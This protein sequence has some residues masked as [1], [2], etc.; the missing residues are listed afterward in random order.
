MLRD[1]E[2][3]RPAFHFIVYPDGETNQPHPR[4]AT[5][6]RPLID[7]LFRL[8][9]GHI[10]IEQGMLHYEDRAA[11]FDYQDRYIPLSFKADDLSVLLRY[12]PAG[13]SAVVVGESYR[14]E[15]GASDLALER[16]GPKSVIPAVHGYVQA[17]L[18]L[19]RNAVYLGSLRLTAR[20]HEGKDHALE[21]S[22]A[23]KDFAQPR[24]QAKMAGELDMRLLDPLTGYTDAPEGM[25]RLELTAAGSAGE[26]RIDGA[27]HVEDGSYIGTGMVASGVGLDAHVHADPE[28]LVI[29]SI[30]A[31]FRQGG[32]MAGVVDLHPWLPAL[33]GAAKLEPASQ[34]GLGKN[35]ADKTGARNRNFAPP[36][37]PPL[38]IQVNG[39]VTA[40]FKDV[41]LDTLLEMVSEAPYQHLGLDALL[42]GTAEA[43]WTN[44]D[45]RTVAVSSALSLS[46]PG[47]ARRGEVPANGIIDA[48]YT[49]RDGAVELRRLEL[50]TP[51]SALEAHGR[52]GAYPITSPTALAVEFHS[53]NLNEFDSVLRDLGLKRNGTSGT[54]ALP[55]KLSGQVDFVHGS[56]AGSLASPHLAG[57]LSATGLAI[58]AAQGKTSQQRM[59]HFDSVSAEGSYAA[60]RINISQAVLRRGKSQISL[61]MAL[62]AA[63]G[64]EMGTAAGMHR[65]GAPAFD[66]NSILH[67]RLQAGKVDLADLQP[68]ISEE[69]PLEGALDAQLEVDG[70]VH[71]LG[72]SGWVEMEGGSVYGEPVAHLRMEGTLANQQ[73]KLT[74]ISA[75]AGRRLADRQRR[76]RPELG[77]VS[78]RLAGGGDRR[79][80]GRMARP[81]RA[82]CGGQ[83]GIQHDGLGDAGRPAAGGP[84][85][86]AR[87]CFR[88]SP[89]G[90][91][92]DHGELGPPLGD[93]RRGHA[94][95][96]GRTEGA[97]PD[98]A[99]RRLRNPGASGV[100]AV[101]YRHPVA[102]QAHIAGL[103][104]ES[105]LAGVAS[106]EGPLKRPELL[107][108]EARLNELAATVSG[109]HLQSEGGVHATLANGRIQLDPLHITGEDTDLRASGGL[110]IE[111]AQRL[112]LAASGSINLRLAET[113]DPDLTTSGLT[114]F[115]VAA[116]GTL[117]HPDLEGRIDFENCSLSLGDIPNGLSQLHGTLE[118]SQNRLVVKTLTAVSGGGLLS[119]G[120]YLSYQHGIYADLSVTGKGIRIRYPEG[121]S[122]QADATLHLQGTQNSLLLSGDV[123][124]TRFTM[125]PEMDLAALAAQANAVQTIAPANAPSNHVRLDVHVTSSPQLN[126]QNAYAKLAGDVDLHLRG[127]LASPALLG[128]VSITEGSAVIAGTHYQLESGD[129]VFSNPVRIEP[130]ID[131]TA[132]ATVEDY[133]ITLGLHGPLRNM[134]V[135]YRSDP[136]MPEADVLALLA[137]GRTESQQRL[138][139]QQQEQTGA[140]QTTN[141]L[142]GG[143]LN[144]TVSS[145]VQ[146]LFGAGSVK[147]DPNYLGALGN[148][149]TR[150]VVE[151]QLGRNVT[152]TYATE[153]NTTGQQLIQADVAVNSHIAL[154]LSRDESGVFSMVLKATRRYR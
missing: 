22:G 100:F 69:L 37:P 29:T 95:R 141:A 120:G 2:I 107:H 26:F 97:R 111:G 42:S 88:G 77:R 127:T 6:H 121:I 109:V 4:R 105:S 130:N 38:T 137:L 86:A 1:L 99:G 79:L 47:H 53:H 136:P 154:Q 31:R 23:L 48:T 81:A 117:Q 153:V 118:F 39:K 82:P 134:T 15:L 7:T 36:P 83:A 67:L 143:A 144:A 60:T 87:V 24:W 52:L 45:S 149:T 98:E 46:P 148:S 102:E 78:N 93:L 126:F 108:G 28:R 63:P 151:E 147:V 132:T 139:T 61:K 113:L 89:V 119:V 68:F 106:V 101:Q 49:Q 10:E 14:I 66:E 74:S 40:Q 92:G 90:R 3:D 30:V 142:L 54:A 25:A 152:L 50:D 11:S 80:P 112:D 62:E 56:W 103:G 91:D 146:K 71:G 124:I 133:N 57:S 114:T 122:S 35:D 5:K 131:L 115:Q 27:V 34:N 12:V 32:Q 110:E 70:P 135:S 58:E 129:L 59:I 75:R 94:A 125:S 84:W 13:D 18:D 9:A 65:S 16:G 55:V 8:Q 104:G 20:S 76:L 150:I 85:H 17:T 128:R 72:G 73:L 43:T 21:I 44:G 96:G 138:F 123:L 33:P 140:S 116:H 41:S 51:A 64:G 19:T 145:R